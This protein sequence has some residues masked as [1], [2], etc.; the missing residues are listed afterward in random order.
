MILDPR[1]AAIPESNRDGENA[2]TI[3]GMN[4]TSSCPPWEKRW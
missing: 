1:L 2:E 3:Q 4:D